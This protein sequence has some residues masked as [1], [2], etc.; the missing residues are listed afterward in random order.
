MGATFSVTSGRELTI[1]HAA[2]LRDYLPI[3]FEIL[4]QVV[5][6]PNYRIHEMPD[7]KKRMALELEALVAH[8]ETVAV[9]LLHAAAYGD[10]ALA[11][12]AAG[13][14]GHSIFAPAHICKSL[15]PERMY[16]FMDQFYTSSGSGAH[17]ALLS[18]GS[19][20]NSSVEQIAPLFCR[21]GRPSGSPAAGAGYLGGE[22]RR[23]IGGPLTAIVLAAQGVSRKDGAT[24]MLASSA[25]RHCLKL[26]SIATVSGNAFGAT[27]VNFN[28]TD[29]GLFGIQLLT[30]TA[31]AGNVSEGAAKI[32]ASLETSIGN[33]DTAK[34]ALKLEVGKQAYNPEHCFEFWANSVLL[35]G[36]TKLPDVEDV[37]KAIDKLTA[38]D[39]QAVAKKVSASWK[40]APS[41]GA[42]GNLDK[43]PSLRNLK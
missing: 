33:L 1:Y 19:P 9:E 42:T 32:M 23:E 38:T 24:A 14:L 26:D 2:V 6:K 39:L 40:S 22:M 3:A 35:D 30:R 36:A 37:F 28:Y 12:G 29:S 34:N 21:E 31:D 10:G 11:T 13:S 15:T 41:M 27:A 20:V 5:A 25:L 8:P 7:V 17:M 4:Q 16:G 18:H 43:T